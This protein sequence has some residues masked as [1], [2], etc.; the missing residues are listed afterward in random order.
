ML[1][2]TLFQLLVSKMVSVEIYLELAFT[3]ATKNKNFR[4]RALPFEFFASLLECKAKYHQTGRSQT[5]NQLTHLMLSEDA[6]S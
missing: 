1:R 6:Y 3:H 5:N 2:D 4:V